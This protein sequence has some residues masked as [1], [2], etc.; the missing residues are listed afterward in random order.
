PSKKSQRPATPLS[1]PRR[2][3]EEN[4]KEAPAQADEKAGGP[5]RRG[6]PIDSRRRAS[7]EERSRQYLKER[8]EEGHMRAGRTPPSQASDARR[9]APHREIDTSIRDMPLTEDAK[10]LSQPGGRLDDFTQTD[11]WR[12][13]RIMGE[14]IE[15]FDVLATLE[16]GVAIFGSA[17]TGPDDPMYQAAQET[18]TLLAK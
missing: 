1:R 3:S 6:R 4:E 12:V 13:L 14:F 9:S 8:T 18:A 11:P 17:R 10:L 7:A 15:G 2:T 5:V 16:K